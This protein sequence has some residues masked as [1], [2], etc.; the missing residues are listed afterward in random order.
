MDPLPG[1]RV[2]ADQSAGSSYLE[3]E[4]HSTQSVVGLES[5]MGPNHYNAYSPEGNFKPLEV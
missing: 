4:G 3:T 2:P 1:A 5:V